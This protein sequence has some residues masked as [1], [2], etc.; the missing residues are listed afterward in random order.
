MTES[1][2]HQDFRR[3]TELVDRAAHAENEVERETPAVRAAELER[4]WIFAAADDW[5]TM[6]NRHEQWCERIDR[7]RATT[8]AQLR[9]NQ[10]L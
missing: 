9:C 3:W 1:E 8:K 10:L 2:L 6:R 5:N 7:R 4:K